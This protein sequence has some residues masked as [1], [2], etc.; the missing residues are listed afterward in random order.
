PGCT[1]GSPRPGPRALAPGP[2][3]GPREPSSQGIA[4]AVRR[5]AVTSRRPPFTGS[6]PPM[7]GQETANT[8]NP[9]WGFRRSH[10]CKPGLPAAL[11]GVI[12]GLVLADHLDL[13][14][15][16]ILELLLPLLRD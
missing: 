11:S 13:D 6:F 8:G 16:G 7:P 15:A 14:L 9:T 12:H 1:G 5:P 4:A 10:H 2:P 3:D